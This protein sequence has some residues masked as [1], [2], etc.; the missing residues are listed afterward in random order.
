M[1]GRSDAVAAPEVLMNREPVVI[2]CDA[3]LIDMDGTLVDSTAVVE[4]HWGAWAAR[5]AM[6]S[7]TSCASRTD[8]PR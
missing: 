2:E 3:L 6:T 4:R 5:H 1:T 8:G 7:P